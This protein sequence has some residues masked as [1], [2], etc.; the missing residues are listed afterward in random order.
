M[1]GIEYTWDKRK[2]VLNLSKH[3][4]DFADMNSF[5]WVIA[6]IVPDK[7]YEDRLIATSYID[8]RLF[9]AVYTEQ[10]GGVIHVISLRKATREEI[11]KYAET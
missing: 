1:R 3:K 6:T 11:R 2:R 8:S 7:E 9:V 10:I 5:N 4:I